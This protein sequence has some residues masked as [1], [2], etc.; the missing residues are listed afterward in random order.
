MYLLG[1]YG[2]IRL[3]QEKSSFFDSQIARPESNHKAVLIKVHLTKNCMGTYVRCLLLTHWRLRG[4]DS[5]ARR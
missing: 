3:L 2:F 4:S 1:K 5:T